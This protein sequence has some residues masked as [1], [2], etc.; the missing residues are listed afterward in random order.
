MQQESAMLLPSI[1]AAYRITPELDVGARF[2]AGNLKSKNQVVVWGTP[3]NW[4]ED[5]R[6]DALFTAG[7]RTRSFRAL[8]MA[9][10]IST[11][12]ISWAELDVPVSS[13]QR[14][15]R[16]AC[17]ARATIRADRPTPDNMAK[18]A[19]VERWR[20]RRPASLQLR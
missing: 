11:P 1:A 12:N 13:R 14:A 18:C 16:R 2:T 6:K 10:R 3:N 7:S 4:E 17:A 8:G 20:R 15:P 9:R 19:T 5:V